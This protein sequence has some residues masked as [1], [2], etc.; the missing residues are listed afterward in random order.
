MRKPSAALV[1]ASA[2]LVMA[3]IG[4]SV[5]ASGYTIT[6]SKQI[7]PGSI[8]LTSLEQ[9][10]TQGTAGRARPA[11]PAGRRW[12][13]RPGRRGW[14]RR[15]GRRGR[16]ELWSRRS[17]PTGRSTPR[18]RASRPAAAAPGI[19]FVNFGQDITECATVAD[20]GL[21][22]QLRRRGPLHD[23][24]PGRRIRLPEQHGS[25][26]RTGLPEPD[27]GPRAD[28]SRQ[29]HGRFHELH[30]RRLLLISHPVSCR[31]Q[32]TGRGHCRCGRTRR[33]PQR[34]D[35]RA[36]RPRQDD[37]RRRDAVAVRRLPRE[38]VGAGSRARFRGSRAR[39]GHHDPGQEHRRPPRRDEDQ[40]HRHARARRLRRRGRARPDD[41][42]RRAAAGRRQRGPA[43][44]DALRAAQGAR[45]AAARDPRRQQD[46]PARTRASPRSWTRSTRCSSTSTP[47][48]SR[49]SSRS[50]TR[51]RAPGRRRSTPTCPGEDLEPLFETLFAT[52]PPPSYEE[53]HPLQ[54]LVTNLDASPYLGR[55]ALCRIRNGVLRR[56]DSVLR[57]RVDG[58]TERVQDHRP[59]GD[60]GAHA[61]GRR[62]GRPG[63]DH[64][65]RRHRGRRDRRDADRPR[66]SAPAAGDQ[67]RRAAACR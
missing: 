28:E 61:R 38:R 27:L 25:R 63:R 22:P 6:S 42:R 35:H 11:G 36:R 5:A 29:R 49:S 39:E 43:A 54:A 26:P 33:H 2:A 30:D 31:P 64:R 53:G 60:R 16:D 66:R 17:R 56:G 51:T 46:R 65:D 12:R 24:H 44:P 18:A 7:K 4:T 14:R 47:T 50:S 23:R 55:L 19:Y 3:T 8:S 57:C 9:G 62:R 45:V 59:H 34:G 48:R 20:A 67:R 58:T 13:R 37:A 15:P 40:H 10:R 32:G 41:G 1:V 52:V 21:D